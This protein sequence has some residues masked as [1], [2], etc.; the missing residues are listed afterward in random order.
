MG[1]FH[2]VILEIDRTKNSGQEEYIYIYMSDR[3]EWSTVY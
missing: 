1:W 2:F 3:K